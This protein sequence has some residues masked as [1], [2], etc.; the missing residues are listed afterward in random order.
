M[1][2]SIAARKVLRNFYQGQAPIRVTPIAEKLGISVRKEP[3]EA[4]VS[5]MLFVRKDE[6]TIVIN[7]S[8]HIH[9][10]RFTLAHEIGHF[11]LHQQYIQ[12][13]EPYFVDTS[14]TFFRNRDSS[15]GIIKQEIEANNFASEL[16]MPEEE[17]LKYFKYK[18]IDFFDGFSIKGLA[19]AFNVSEQAMAIKIGQLSNPSIFK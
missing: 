15:T 9:R 19:K 4:S 2:P 7:S 16:L 3:M 13:D 12:Q 18:K 10:R 14:F 5:G 11:I 6:P 17:I 8:H 1:N